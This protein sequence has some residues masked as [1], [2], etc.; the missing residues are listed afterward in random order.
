[1]ACFWFNNF[2]NNNNAMLLIYIYYLYVSKTYSF[3][4]FSENDDIDND[5]NNEVDT[6]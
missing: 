1:M 3:L 4:S 2:F 6:V 5:I